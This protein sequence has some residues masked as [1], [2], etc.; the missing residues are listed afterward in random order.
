LDSGQSFSDISLEKVE[1]RK[2]H[3]KFLINKSSEV[4]EMVVGF[5]GEDF[6][7]KVLVD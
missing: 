2:K 4:I 6:R 5:G 7:T 3:T 1:L